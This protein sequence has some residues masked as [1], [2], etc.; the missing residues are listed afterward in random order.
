MNGGFQSAL[1]G[2]LF[3]Q[4]VFEDAIAFLYAHLFGH[5]AISNN[6]DKYV[7]VLLF[8]AVAC[9]KPYVQPSRVIAFTRS[10]SASRACQAPASNVVEQAFVWLRH[11]AVYVLHT[12]VI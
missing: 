9:F 2:E 5:N 3:E 8:F 6:H 7:P 4:A 10:F 1:M 11:L 12:A